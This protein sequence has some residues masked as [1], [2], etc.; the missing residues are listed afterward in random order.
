MESVGVSDPGYKGKEEERMNKWR[1]WR[2]LL[3][4][5]NALLDEILQFA[6]LAQQAVPW[7]HSGLS[8]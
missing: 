7:L 1:R 4:A 3:T 5:L 8:S 6:V 2:A